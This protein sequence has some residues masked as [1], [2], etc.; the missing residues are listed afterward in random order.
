MTAKD[1]TSVCLLFSVVAPE[2]TLK[3]QSS[4]SARDSLVELLILPPQ[5]LIEPTILEGEISNIE[6]ICV[7][8]TM[9][10]QIN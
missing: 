3:S 4:Q 6:I 7:T 1:K 9:I 5:V 8:Q 2:G 10:L